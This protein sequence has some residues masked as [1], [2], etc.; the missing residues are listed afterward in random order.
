MCKQTNWNS[1]TVNIFKYFSLISRSFY[2]GVMHCRDEQ[3]DLFNAMGALFSSISFLG[4]QYG[5]TI[6][7][8]VA[9]ERTVFYREK[10]AGMYSALPYALSQVSAHKNLHIYTNY[11]SSFKL[12]NNFFSCSFSLRFL[13]SY[14][15]PLDM[16]S[17]C[18]KWWDSIGPLKSSSGSYISCSSHWCSLSYTAWWLLL[19]LLI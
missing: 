14:P 19:S 12:L 3:Q 8:V 10:A 11:L 1:R 7:P 17:L 2:S 16:V 4:F 15:N 9:T 5:S 6:Q 18:M 13:I